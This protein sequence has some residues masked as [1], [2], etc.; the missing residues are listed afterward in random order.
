MRPDLVTAIWLPAGR[1]ELPQVSVT[2][3]S[4]TCS[5]A[6][7]QPAAVLRTSSTS[8]MFMRQ[9]F[10]HVWR[11]VRPDRTGCRSGNAG[12]PDYAPGETHPRAA[13]SPEFPV[14]LVRIR[15]SATAD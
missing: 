15:S 1:G 6:A 13:A 4:A 12:S 11:M 14:I 9:S 2:V 7:R 8:E 3:A 10:Q 5:P